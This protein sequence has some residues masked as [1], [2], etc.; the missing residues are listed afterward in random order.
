MTGSVIIIGAGLSGLY[1]ATLLEKA[2]VEYVIL[3]A[4]DRTGGRVLSPDVAGL[5]VDMGAA[6]FWPQL[7]PEFAQ[8]I[9]QTGTDRHPTGATGRYVI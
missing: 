8:L 9:G 3:E 2:G 7:Q 4:R 1:A 5:H 6:W